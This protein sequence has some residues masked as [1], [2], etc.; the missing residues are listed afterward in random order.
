M[1]A[2]CNFYYNIDVVLGFEFFADLKQQVES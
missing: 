2:V 1:G